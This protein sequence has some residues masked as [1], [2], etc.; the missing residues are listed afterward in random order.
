M[1]SVAAVVSER[2]TVEVPF[3]EQVQGLN[4]EYLEGD[5]DV[6]AFTER[7]SFREVLLRDRLRSA[8]KHVNRDGSDATW[9]DDARA[10]RAIVQLERVATPGGLVATNQAVMELLLKGV[11][12]EGDERHG[13]RDVTV[14]FIDWDHPERNNF[15]AINQFRVDPVGPRPSIIPDVVLFVNGIPLVVVEAKSPTVVEPLD[16]AITQLLRYSNQRGA[17][18]EEGVERLFH[19]NALMIG[20]SFFEA[21]FA[22]VGASYE[23]FMPW[24][25]TAPVPKEAVAADLGVD[26]LTEQQSLVAGMLRPSNLLEII[27]SF[28]VFDR[29]DGVLIKKVCR[30]QQFRAVIW[31]CERLLRD[32][33]DEPGRLDNGRGGV[34]WHTQGS[35]KSLTMVFLVRRMRTMPVLRRYKVVVVTDRKD[36]EDQL[37]E[38]AVLTGETVRRATGRSNLI[39]HLRRPGSG[40]VMAMLQK[41][42]PSDDLPDA[43]NVDDL[44]FPVCNESGEILLLVD[45]AHRGQTGQLHASLIRALPN[46]A[47]V[48]FTGTPILLGDG[49]RTNEIFGA[50]IDVYTIAMSEKDGATVPIYYEGRESHYAVKSPEEMNAA[51]VAAYPDATPEELEAAKQKITS[52]KVL[53]APKS[54]EAKAEDI[55]RHYVDV[56]MP[57]GLKAQVVAVSRRAALR[58]RAALAAARDRLVADLEADAV[59]LAALPEDEIDE[60]EGDAGFRARAFRHL[61]LI[62]RL[63]F[64]AIISSSQNQDQDLDEWSDPVKGK[65]R[66]AAFKKPLVHDD[67]TRASALAFLCVKSMLLTGFNARGEQALYLDRSLQGAELLQAIARVNRT[68]PGKENGLVVDYYGLGDQLSE[69]LKVYARADIEGAVKGITADALPILEGR[70]RLLVAVFTD[71]GLDIGQLQQCIDLLADDGLRATFAKHFRSFLAGLEAVMPRPAGLKYQRAAKVLSLINEEARRRYRDDNLRI[72]PGAGRKVQALVNAHLESLGIDQR[73]API[74]ITDA[75]FDEVVRKIPSNRAKASEFEHAARYHI[76]SH[77]DGDPIRYRKL[78]DRLQA[79][80]DRFKNEWDELARQLEMFAQEIRAEESEVDRN[81]LDPRVEAPFFR[82][83]ADA[84]GDTAEAQPLVESTRGLVALI[85]GEASAVD[86]WRNTLAQDVLRSHVVQYLDETGLV[87]DFDRLEIVAGEVMGVARTQHG[88]IVA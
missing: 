79:I 48:A 35:G 8:I 12:M 81:G 1:V 6:P 15:L 29:E 73:V 38:T 33:V 76:T 41:Y 32:P 24:K 62:R 23:H 21:V 28:T 10:E 66:I 47:K 77:L 14:Q 4:W 80:L 26:S 43:T 72:P 67:P 52:A 82:I 55:L 50:F 87:A 46:A 86:F 56:V 17:E 83:L 65:S 58:Y 5:R 13:G 34:I 25:D 85:R 20:T 71:N 36:L 49:P 51:L 16:A 27:R 54:I 60:M 40:L 78:S 69:A 44:D 57:G 45:E 3:I 2:A 42:R 88:W 84:A 68:Y 74:G 39:R 11:A 75:R 19:F 53:E 22:S 59:T 63:E 7:T 31:T 64:A 30:Y 37:E 18:Q 61:A 70:Y 9:V